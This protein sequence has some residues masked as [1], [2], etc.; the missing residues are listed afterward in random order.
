MSK[1]NL[2]KGS[3]DFTSEP[4]W[5]RLLLI[6]MHYLTWIIILLIVKEW[7]IPVYGAVKISGFSLSDIIKAFKSRS[8]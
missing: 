8:P 3:F 7:I 6:A 2:F 1:Y 4:L 5:F